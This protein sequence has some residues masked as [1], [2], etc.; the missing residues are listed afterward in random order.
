LKFFLLL[1]TR[2]KVEYF[3]HDEIEGNFAD[4]QIFLEFKIIS[5]SEIIKY[6]IY[7]LDIKKGE[8]KKIN[9]KHVCA[10]QNIQA[11]K[12]DSR[13]SSSGQQLHSKI[14]LEKS[15]NYL[16]NLI[17]TDSDGRVNAFNKPIYIPEKMVIPTNG[18]MFSLYPLN[19]IILLFIFLI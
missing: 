13:F 18:N 19:W 5:I 2:P 1:D 11:K 4:R 6:E 12:L 10:I 8:E 17:V 7:A 9:M 14:S 3:K 15:K 16:L